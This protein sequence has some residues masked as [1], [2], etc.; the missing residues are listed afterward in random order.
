MATRQNDISAQA[1]HRPRYIKV[2]AT[3]R[4]WISQGTYRTG[5][6]LPTESE[7][8]GLFQVSRITTRKAVDMLV[9][10]GLVTRQPG[11]GTFVVDDLADAP[12]TGDMEQLLRKVQRLDN[13]TQIVDTALE[14]VVADAATAKDLALES[15]SHVL[16]ATHLRLLDG[17]PIGYVEAFVPAD[18]GL[19]FTASE[20]RQHPL[21]ILL[22]RKGIKVSA[23]DQLIGA[24]LADTRMARMLGTTV[25]A[26]LV[27]IQL[28]VFDDSQRPVERMVAWYRADHYQHHVY[29]TRKPGE[30]LTAF[31]RSAVSGPRRKR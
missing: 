22:E 31:N 6:Q 20:I 19:R 4:D 29:L 21:L 25:G 24:A 9:D 27:K 23:A 7:L 14:E 17:Q 3:I 18:L 15:G 16:R 5:S 8:C 26:P 30:A 1:L 28:I 10:E 2:Y 12:V 13:N 11:R